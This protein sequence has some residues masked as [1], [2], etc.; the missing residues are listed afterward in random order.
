MDELVMEGGG[1]GATYAG[2]GAREAVTWLWHAKVGDAGPTVY[3]MSVSSRTREVGDGRLADYGPPPCVPRGRLFPTHPNQHAFPISTTE[4]EN[5][6]ENHL[7]YA[8]SSTITKLK[9]GERGGGNPRDGL[10]TTDATRLYFRRKCGEP[11]DCWLKPCF[12]PYA[13][14]QDSSC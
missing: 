14:R 5:Q 4:P 7:P 8:L 6:D 13:Q 2:V 3:S 12:A 11:R 1:N 10:H 9:D